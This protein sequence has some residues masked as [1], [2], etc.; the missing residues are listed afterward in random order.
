MPTIY[1]LAKHIPFDYDGSVERGV[2]LR[3][4]AGDTRVSAALF[5]ALLRHFH[6]EVEGGF[7]FIAPPPGGLGEWVQDNSA[8]TPKHASHIAAIL[9]HEGYIGYYMRGKAVWLQ[10]PLSGREEATSCLEPLRS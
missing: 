1:T 9:A 5:R 2:T 3:F 4:P 10:F 6:G 8:L 7:N